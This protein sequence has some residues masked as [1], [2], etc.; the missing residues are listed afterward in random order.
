VPQVE[1]QI[2]KLKLKFTQKN[3]FSLKVKTVIRTK[4]WSE[5]IIIYWFQIE[6]FLGNTRQNH[7]LIY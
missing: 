2:F 4:R 7:I 6:I 1:I 5:L 3:F